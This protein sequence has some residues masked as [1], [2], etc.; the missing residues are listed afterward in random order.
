[1]STVFSE[2]LTKLRREAGFPTASMYH[3]NA[4]ARREAASTIF[5]T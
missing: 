3:L 2:V 1:M 5:F 4:E